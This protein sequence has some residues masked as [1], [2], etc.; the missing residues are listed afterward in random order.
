MRKPFLE[1]SWQG[2]SEGDNYCGRGWF[3][4][5]TPDVGEG[6]LLIHCGDESSIK[7]ERQLTNASNSP[8]NPRA[9]TAQIAPSPLCKTLC[10]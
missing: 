5:P 6:E 7:V 2:I 10:V 4:F 3:E 8:Q 9:G 1:N